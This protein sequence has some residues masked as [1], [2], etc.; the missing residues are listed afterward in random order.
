MQTS[1]VIVSMSFLIYLVTKEWS[2]VFTVVIVGYGVSLCS[3]INYAEFNVVRRRYV[4]TN[5]KVIANFNQVDEDICQLNYVI[6]SLYNR[7]SQLH[8]DLTKLN[9]NN[10]NFNKPNIQDILSETT[11]GIWSLRVHGYKLISFVT[12]RYTDIRLNLSD[13]KRSK[14]AE[15]YIKQVY[16]N[17]YYLVN[18]QFYNM[19]TAKLLRY[20]IVNG[21]LYQDFKTIDSALVEIHH[22]ALDAID[23]LYKARTKLQIG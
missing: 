3:N 16:L 19:P 21:S 23:D 10:L 7:S 15:V 6:G 17:I 1:V 8:I 2:D 14:Q 9:Q 11:N 5:E 13:D 12:S 4:K 20:V 18:H 22:R